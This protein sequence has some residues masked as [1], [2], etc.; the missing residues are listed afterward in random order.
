MNQ[1]FY[2]F[3]QK[4]DVDNK[5]TLA[6]AR[7]DPLQ[8]EWHVLDGYG[9][10]RARLAVVNTQ[11]GVIVV[12]GESSNE[13]TN[14]CQINDTDVSCSNME[15]NYPESTVSDGEIILFTF[16]HATCPESVKRAEAMLLLATYSPRN[17]L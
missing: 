6:V 10:P 17:E 13:M 14:L 1:S 11:H 4:I 12:D 3:G 7:F 16:D 9:A 2:L 5:T 8:N 15:I